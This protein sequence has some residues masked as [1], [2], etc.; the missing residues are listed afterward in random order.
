MVPTCI[1]DNLENLTPNWPLTLTLTFQ[2]H[3]VICQRSNPNT[4]L[5]IIPKHNEVLLAL[6]KLYRGPRWKKWK[7]QQ[8]EITVGKTNC[9]QTLR[10]FN[11]INFRDKDSFHNYVSNKCHKKN[12]GLIIWTH[13]NEKYLNEIVIWT[14]ALENFE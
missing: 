8:G 7:K 2:G 6:Y 1:S 10:V 9:W 5:H 4:P 12:F 3:K 14:Q 11:I 13:V